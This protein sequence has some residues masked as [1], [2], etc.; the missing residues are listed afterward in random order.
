MT[1]VQRIRAAL[2][3]LERQ[4]TGHDVD[5][6]IPLGDNWLAA[7]NWALRLEREQGVDHQAA[8]RVV[9]AKHFVDRQGRP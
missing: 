1:E 2:P 8:L 7:W 6:V 9:H 4:F 5:F 3:S